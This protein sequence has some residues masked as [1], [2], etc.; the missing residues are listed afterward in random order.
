M[1]QGS[2]FIID[3]AGGLAGSRHYLSF[4]LNFVKRFGA[5]TRHGKLA[6]LFEY[7]S[8]LKHPDI[9]KYTRR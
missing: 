3:W 5:I 9:L 1:Q 7:A 2:T 6:G 4:A 8:S